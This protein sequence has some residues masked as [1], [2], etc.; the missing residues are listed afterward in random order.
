M[1]D[2]L[3]WGYQL[4]PDNPSVRELAKS[5]LDISRD[6]LDAVGGSVLSVARNALA[7]VLTRP[8]GATVLITALGA[9]TFCR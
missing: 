6:A 4:F 7:F 9:S 2:R 3:R 5:T 8:L 1:T